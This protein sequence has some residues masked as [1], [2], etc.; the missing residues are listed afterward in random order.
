[1]DNSIRTWVNAEPKASV[2]VFDRGFSFG[3]GLFETIRINGARAP[4]LEYHLERLL[5]GAEKLGISITEKQ[6]R[7][8]VYKALNSVTDQKE[9]V[10]RLKYILTRG[11]SDSGYTPNPKGKPTR[12]MQL[13][14]FDAGLNRLLQQQGIKACTCNW[15]LSENSYLVGLKH[16]NRIDQVMARHEWLDS[17]CYEGLMLDQSGRYIEGTSSNLFA[18]TAKDEIITPELINCGVN[19]VMRRAIIE[20]L[21]PKIGQECYEAEINGVENFME[22]FVSN[23]LMGILPITRVDNISFEVGP[24]TRALQDALTESKLHL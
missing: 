24:V 9:S 23:A 5:A 14:S 11:E 10:W 19:G 2:S 15:R 13:Q 12:V 6:V 1:M 4:L 3:D 16:L 17:D 20:D 8:D 21:C 7:G 22:L 18:V